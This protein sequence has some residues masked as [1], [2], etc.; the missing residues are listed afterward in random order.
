MKE[1]DYELSEEKAIEI[2]IFL[3]N[4]RVPSWKKRQ[5]YGQKHNYRLYY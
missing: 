1:R 3:K 5:S 4:R 2:G